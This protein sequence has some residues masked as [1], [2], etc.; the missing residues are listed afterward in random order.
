MNLLALG[1]R[2]YT[3]IHTCAR[4]SQSR[5]YSEVLVVIFDNPVV[6]PDINKQIPLQRFKSLL[7]VPHIPTY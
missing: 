2:Y 6:W 7:N 5:T 3:S 4:K 1:H